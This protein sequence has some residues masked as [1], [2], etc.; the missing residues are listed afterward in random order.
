MKVSRK[1]IKQIIQEEIVNVVNEHVAPE[2]RIMK[3]QDFS[4]EEEADLIQDHI[5]RQM[6]A[7]L[8]Q[9]LEELYEKRGISTDF[10][11]RDA[12]ALDLRRRIEIEIE[13]KLHDMTMAYVLQG[14][15]EDE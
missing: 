6:H 10:P 4:V 11:E 9:G 12:E 8:E 14:N 1:K 5:L 15:K 13:N 3:E 7:A 2:N